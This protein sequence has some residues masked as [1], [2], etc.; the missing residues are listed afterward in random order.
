MRL[1]RAQPLPTH[2]PRCIPCPLHFRPKSPKRNFAMITRADGLLDHRLT[3]GKQPGK[4]HAR[5]H[6]R[7]RDFRPVMNRLQRTTVNFQWRPSAFRGLDPRA[8]LGKR[9]QHCI[10]VRNGL[11][12]RNANHSAHRTRRT[13]DDIRTTKLRINNHEL[14]IAE[15]SDARDGRVGTGA[16][17]VQAERS[18]AAARG[19]RNSAFACEARPT[20][21]A[22]AQSL[23]RVSPAELPAASH[24]IQT[25]ALPSRAPTAPLPNAPGQTSPPA[26]PS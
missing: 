22:R 9:R 25:W 15:I 6:L 23:P 17:P 18:S 5:L 8:H 24:E 12:A 7:A 16:S 10:T 26:A 13:N 1:N 20:T 11:I 21:P 14:N 4:Q 3:L 19:Q 2:N